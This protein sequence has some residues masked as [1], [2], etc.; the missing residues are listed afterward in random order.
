MMF[1]I[2]LI[3]GGFVVLV[4]MCAMQL[5]RINDAVTTVKQCESAMEHERVIAIKEKRSIEYI[6]GMSR[7]IGL[8]KAF[9]E[10]ELE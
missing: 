2:G 6:N 1:F 5:N 4:L 8:F 3:V 10:E 7:A 9:Y